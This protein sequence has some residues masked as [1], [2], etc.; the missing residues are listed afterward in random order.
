MMEKIEVTPMPWERWLELV[1]GAE[2]RGHELL[3]LWLCGQVHQERAAE[4][5]ARRSRD[6]RILQ[7][8]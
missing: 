3:R 8:R 4:V 5:R 7:E 1:E 6:R 2:I